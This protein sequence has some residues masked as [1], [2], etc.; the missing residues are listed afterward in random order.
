M[1]VYISLQVLLM[2]HRRL[3]HLNVSG[4]CRLSDEMFLLPVDHTQNHVR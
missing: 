4:C 3:S 2:Y 1:Y